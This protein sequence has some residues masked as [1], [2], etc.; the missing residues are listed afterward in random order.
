M[1]ALGE[2]TFSKKIGRKRMFTNIYIYICISICIYTY[3]YI[4]INIYVHV[5]MLTHGETKWI[6]YSLDILKLGFM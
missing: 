1:L 2:L 6:S 5:I 4:Y 3:L